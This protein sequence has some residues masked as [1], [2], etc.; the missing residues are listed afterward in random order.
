MRKLTLLCVVLA[1]C[2][3][4]AL[5]SPVQKRRPNQTGPNANQNAA[6]P[7]KSKEVVRHVFDELFTQGRY[8]MIPQVYHQDCIVHF[9]N[10]TN[11]L[12]ESVAEGKGWRTA[13][14][15]L[16]MTA[17][18]M[19]VAG[20]RVTVRWTAQGTNT[21]RGNGLIKPTGKRILMH[22]KSVFRVADGKIVE[23]WNE[24]NRDD[25]YHQL[26]VNPKLAQLYD[27]TQDAWAALQSSVPNPRQLEA[28]LQSSK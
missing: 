18:Q 6:S 14:P 8:E 12:Q 5:A 16:R 15:D 10:R 23:V 2:I 19:S 26:G 22:G 3:A 21:G 4:L 20:D 28:S 27:L 24:Y 11:S 1:A 13:A 7:E 17:D 9:R 25:I